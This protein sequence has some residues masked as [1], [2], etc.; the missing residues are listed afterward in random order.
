MYKY[1]TFLFMGTTSRQ[2][3]R[4]P[5]KE[6]VTGPMLRTAVNSLF[7]TS[8]RHSA[9]IIPKAKI[10]I[11]FTWYPVPLEGFCDGVDEK[12]KDTETKLG[13]KFVPSINDLQ[14]EL[15]VAEAEFEKKNQSLE[16]CGTAFLDIIIA[17]AWRLS[18]RISRRT[19]LD[20]YL[21]INISDMDINHCT[22]INKENDILVKIKS[23]TVKDLLWKNYFATLTMILSDINGEIVYK[24]FPKYQSTS[25]TEDENATTYWG[26]N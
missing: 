10:T 25:V 17:L 12:I 20:D 26:Y 19:L 3:S 2:N 24:G 13:T 5:F 21:N 14:A 22:Y 4:K 18:S 16:I 6:G 7:G 8:P 9:T 15:R 23:V 1:A 11:K